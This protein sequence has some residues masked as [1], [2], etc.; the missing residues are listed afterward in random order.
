MSRYSKIFHHITVDDVKKKRQDN[1]VSEK[2]KLEEEKKERELKELIDSVVEKTKSN[3]IQEMMT[4]GAV[5]AATLTG[6]EDDPTEVA[7]IDTTTVDAFEDSIDN[8]LEHMMFKGVTVKDGGSGSGEG[9]GFN[10]GNI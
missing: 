3:W 7:N 6:S 4:T 9:G 1:I 2:I 10:I 8:G 5:F